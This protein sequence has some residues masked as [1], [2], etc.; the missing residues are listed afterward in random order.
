MRASPERLG[1]ILSISEEIPFNV[2]LLC[3]AVWI[4]KDGA[5]EVSAG[6]LARAMEYILASE[7]EY[8]SS[9]WD[10]FSLHQRR[11]LLMKTVIQRATRFPYPL[12]FPP[13]QKNR[14]RR[15][16][17]VEQLRQKRT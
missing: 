11:T 8:Y 1:D 12:V 7:N 6:D 10:R 4:V 5:G 9:L 2:Q 14:G 3:H 16:S 13:D 15:F 17:L